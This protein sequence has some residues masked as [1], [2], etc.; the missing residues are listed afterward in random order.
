LDQVQLTDARSREEFVRRIAAQA[1]KLRK[2][3]W[4]LGG[5][6]DEQNWSPPELPA[7]DWI[8]AVTPDNP[9]FVERHDGHEALA[10]A[11]AMKLAGI[12]SATKSP[13]GGEIVHDAQGNPTGVFKDAAQSLIDSVIP[14]PGLETR[15]RGARRALEQA[16]SLGVTS[17]QDMAVSYG[18]IAAYS[19]LAERGELTSRIYA[20]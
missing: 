9:V 17:V 10:N 20:A 8:D 13:A 11:L 1:R 14:D 3:E 7:H 15:I 5:D 19:V 12:T 16:A 6:W 4:I 2:G 18:D